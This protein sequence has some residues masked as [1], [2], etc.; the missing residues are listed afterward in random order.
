MPIHPEH[1]E[2]H[3][4]RGLALWNLGFRPFYLLAS[5]FSVVAA[6]AWTAQYAQW[7]L[8]M[9]VIG[10]RVI[11]SL[12]T[13]TCRTR[14]R[15]ATRPWRSWH[16]TRGCCCWPQA[17]SDPICS[18]VLY[19]SRHACACT[20]SPAVADLTNGPKRARMGFARGSRLDRYSPAFARAG[21]GEFH[22]E[23]LAIDGR[24]G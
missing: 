9:A 23:S 13:T 18:A 14:R 10:G 7:L 1:V 24:P 11:P 12:P 8:V 21:P 22:A 5:I 6:L 15:A 4:S 17:Y 16:W 3:N 2:L 20:A 19:L